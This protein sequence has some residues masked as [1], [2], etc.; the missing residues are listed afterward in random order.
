[1]TVEP[2]QPHRFDDAPGVVGV[3]RQELP[4]LP[5]DMVA[6]PQAGRIDPRRWFAH[7]ERSLE[8][9]IGPGKGTFLLGQA[10]AHPEINLLGIEWEGEFYGYTADRV[11]RAALKNVRMLHAD[12]AEFLRWRVPDAV[13][14]VIH[15]YF[16]DPWPKK[17]HFKR[18]V[19][20]DRFLLDAHRVLAAGG[21]LRVVTD[22]DELWEWDMEHFRKVTGEAPGQAGSGQTDLGRLFEMRPFTPPPWVG[23]GQLVGTNY[24]RKFAAGKSPHACVLVRAVTS[25]AALSD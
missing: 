16:S 3:A 18:R 7:P 4:A 9:E 8:V 17:R 11:R 2:A 25:N 20:Q 6:N 21:E 5:D 22:H 1:M 14:S 19:I 24:E 13:V 15:L 23:E 10:R 12:A